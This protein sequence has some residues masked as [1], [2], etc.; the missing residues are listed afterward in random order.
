MKNEDIKRDM[1]DRQRLAMA[2]AVSL[3][4]DT[5]PTTAASS[6]EAAHSAISWKPSLP[7]VSW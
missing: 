5:H 7:P 6:E 4:R 1:T 3:D 2:E